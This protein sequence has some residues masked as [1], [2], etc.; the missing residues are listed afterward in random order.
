MVF[1]ETLS[2]W[3]RLI[4][5]QVNVLC[6]FSGALLKMCSLTIFYSS[7]PVYERHK[8]IKLLCQWVHYVQFL[9]NPG[10]LSHGYELI[11]NRTER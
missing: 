8:D 2:V 1:R 3:L 11:T 4:S 7:F 5:L 10:A 6:P 9:S